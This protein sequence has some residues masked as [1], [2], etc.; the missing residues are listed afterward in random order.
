VQWLTP[1][2]SAT[3]EVDGDQEDHGSRPAQI[4]VSEISSQQ[5]IPATQEAQ[6]G[7]SWGRH[8]KKKKKK[9]TPYLRDNLKAK[10][11]EG[12]SQVVECL[13]SKY[14]VLSSSPRTTRK[15]K[16]NRMK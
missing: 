2:I 5:A 14:K 12:M 9:V 3:W 1:E 8:Q 11:A 16:I 13:P 10:K 7:G 15:L 6:G 4:K